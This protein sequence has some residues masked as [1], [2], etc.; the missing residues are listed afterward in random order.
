M[1]EISSFYLFSF[2][3]KV[4]KVK[5][6]FLFSLTWLYLLLNFISF[7]IYRRLLNEKKNQKY[8]LFVGF[9]YFWSC[10]IFCHILVGI[11]FVNWFCMFFGFEIMFFFFRNSFFFSFL[12]I[13]SN[14][15]TWWYI[16]LNDHSLLLYTSGGYYNN[17]KK[18]FHL[19]NYLN[20]TYLRNEQVEK[21]NRLN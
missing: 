18:R 6:F 1:P 15:N 17:Y 14:Y 7:S 4:Y 2:Y 9:F 3:H 5:L 16:W 12:Y 21:C 8:H 13:W 10:I 11:F 19:K 20:T